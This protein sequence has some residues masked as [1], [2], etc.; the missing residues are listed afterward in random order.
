VLADTMTAFN[1]YACHA[2][3]GVGG[4]ERDR[5]PLFRTTIQEMGDEGRVPPPLDGVGDKLNNDWLKHVLRDG[6]KDR[7]YMLT[8][9]P[10][11]QLANLDALVRAFVVTDRIEAA[12]VPQSHEPEHRLKATGRQL[13]GEQSL[14]CVKCH[15][16]G[17]HRAT[18]I[19]ALDLQ[20]MTR[21]LREDWFHRYMVKPQA[22]RPG[23]RMPTGFPNGQA[24]IR[25]VYDG[26]P[27]RQLAAIWAYLKDGNKAGV[28]EGVIGKLIE[29]K[30]EQNP[31]LYRAF[32][33]GLS[34][35]GIAVG[36]PEKCHLA[37]DANRMCL[38]LL[39]HG[40][41]IDASMHWEGRGDGFQRPLGDHVIRW[42]ETAPVAV[43]TST[44]A[45]W[46][47]ESPK[48]RGYA[49]RGYRLNERK[50][51]TFLYQTPQFR[52]EDFPQ[53]VARGAEGVFTRRLTITAAEPVENVYVRV[54]AGRKIEPQADGAFLVNGAVRVKLTSAATSILRESNGREELLVPL[55]LTT[56]S[57]E[58]IKE[59]VW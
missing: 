8:R 15:T 41:F 28:P 36:Y 29:L 10:R 43:L 33:E 26:D 38:A 27:R 59:I 22:Y 37:W 46:P 19:Q 21:R 53:P 20:T 12:D 47:G 48:D 24:T 34:P 44:D 13:V 55:D 51:P 1:C 16:F 25:D 11:F 2:R 31:I 5:N 7:P 14:G 42:E 52:V 57:A 9:M 35:R 30:P 23:T 40:R 49:F 45:P 39:W 6:A 56:G 4:P 3:H 18:G 17:R 54:A 50:Q 58:V 32:L